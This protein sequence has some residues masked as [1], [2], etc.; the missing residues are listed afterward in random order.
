M[1]DKGTPS[2]Q[3]LLEAAKREDWDFVDANISSEHLTLERLQ[4]AKREGLVDADQNVRDFAATLLDESDAVLDKVDQAWLAGQMAEDD[5]PIVRY[6]LAIALYKRGNRSPEVVA[7]MKEASK[8]PDVGELATIY[9][10]A[11]SK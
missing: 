7:M 6:R 1:K 8:D 5:H 11:N 4:W 9:L 3:D 10:N 2:F